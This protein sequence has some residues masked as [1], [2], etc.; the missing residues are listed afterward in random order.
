MACGV[1]TVGSQA[2]GIP[3]LVLHGKTGYLS[4]IGDTQ[5][6]AENAIRLLTDDRLAA[7]FREACLHRAHHDF[8]MMPSVMNMNKYTIVYWDEKFPI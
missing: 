8:A 3:E 1:P 7:D 6:M 5:S 2:G 4:P